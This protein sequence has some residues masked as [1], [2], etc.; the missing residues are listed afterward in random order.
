MTTLACADVPANPALFVNQAYA[1][2]ERGENCMRRL[3]VVNR[4][5]FFLLVFDWGLAGKPFLK[6]QDRA[7]IDAPQAQRA[8]AKIQTPAAINSV[9]FKFD[10]A[11]RDRHFAELLFN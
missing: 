8:P 6:G 2:T 9:L 5:L 1:K 7:P 4:R 11:R 10:F 3:G